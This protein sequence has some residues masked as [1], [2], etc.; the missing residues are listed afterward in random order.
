M[1]AGAV[2]GRLAEGKMLRTTTYAALM[3]IAMSLGWLAL[4]EADS[5]RPFNRK[6]QLS[7]DIELPL[8]ANLVTSHHMV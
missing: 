5:F 4:A 8:A 2:C 7:G 3:L 1:K 6:P